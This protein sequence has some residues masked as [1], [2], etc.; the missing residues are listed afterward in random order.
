M[1]DVVIRACIGFV[2]VAGVLTGCQSGGDQPQ[3]DDTQAPPTTPETS[4]E[5]EGPLYGGTLVIAGSDPG[6]LNPAVTSAGNVHPVTGHIFNG[7]VRLDHDFQPQP[8]LAEDWEVSEDGTTY[9]FELAEA[10]WHDG[11]PF[12]SADVKFTF[13]E[14]LTEEHPRTRTAL[15][16]ILDGIDTPDERTVVFRLSQPYAPFLKLIDEDNGAILPKH[17][18]EGTDPRQN[19]ASAEPVGTGPFMFESKEADRITLVRNP[20]YFKEGEPYL[21]EVVFR[22]MPPG[23]QATQALLAG[24]AD[25]ISPSDPDVERVRQE[26]GVVVTER[27]REG[28]ARVV[29]LIPNMEREPWDDVRVRQAVAY[30]IGNEGRELISEAA[31]SGVMKPATGPISQDFPPWYTDDVPDYPQDLDKARQLLDEAGLVAGDDGVRF[32]VS[33]IYDQ[34]F[35]NAA[36]LVIQQLKEVGIVL[37]PEV[38][39]FAAW[40]KKLYIDKDFDLGYSQLTDPPDPDIGTRRAY[41]C[42]NIAPAPFSNG[43]SY[44]NRELD[45]LWVEAAAEADRDRRVELYAE[46]QRIIVE[47]Q[48]QFFLV[49]GIGPYAYN[50]EFADVE[51]AGAKVPYYV[52][53]TAW[54]TQGSPEPQ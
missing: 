15:G 30:A 35:A 18:F 13:E 47:D 48:P 10:S 14:V 43:S 36:D 33:F 5:A 34:G 46:I 2:A 42:D 38:M 11:E 4:P 25:W 20:D 24:E 51:E 32:R 26:E 54:W 7:L 29:R 31:Y 37:E 1:R 44:C 3:T 23:P 19:P 17:L 22:F 16:P 27:G 9:T 49:D 41:D 40:V 39:E 50:D 6:T 53:H 28:F 8:D 21:D 12:T 52:G 45:E